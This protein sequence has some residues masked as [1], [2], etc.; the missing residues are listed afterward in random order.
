[1][2]ARDEIYAIRFQVTG[3]EEF[4]QAQKAANQL[5]ATLKRLGQ[6]TKGSGLND[7]T[8]ELEKNRK[9]LRRSSAAFQNIGYQVADFAVQVEAGTSVARAFGQQASQAFAI[10]GLQSK[11]FVGLSILAALLPGAISLFKSMT[12][13]A[14]ELA[15]AL[16][17]ASDTTDEFNKNSEGIAKVL[18]L[19]ADQTGVLRLELGRYADQLNK[20][21]IQAFVDQ[22]KEL[23]GLSGSNWMTDLFGDY[24]SK[25]AQLELALTGT[26]DKLGITQREVIA[27]NDALARITVDSTVE[28]YEN[29]ANVVS[30]IT[31]N[32]DE[33][34]PVAARTISLVLETA[35]AVRK[36]KEE[37]DGLSDS[38][39]KA[40]IASRLE[41]QSK[42]LYELQTT[43]QLIKEGWKVADA[44]LAAERDLKLLNAESEA[45]RE[46]LR[47]EFDARDQ[48]TEALRREKLA[49][50][51]LKKTRQSGGSTKQTDDLVRKVQALKEM[52]DPLERYAAKMRELREIYNTGSLSLDHYNAA[53]KKYKE[54]LIKAQE[55]TAKASEYAKDTQSAFTSFFDSAI[56]GAE[57][58]KESLKSLVKQLLKVAAQRYIIDKFFPAARGGVFSSLGLPFGVYNQPTYVGGGSRINAYAR[59]TLIGESGA[60]AVLPLT[61]T[62][63]GLGVSTS[64]AVNVNVYNN[65]PG[66]EVKTR[67]ESDGSIGIII[68][69]VRAALTNDVARGGNQFAS[70][71]EGAY[72]VNRSRSRF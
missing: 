45:V 31:S 60:E 52:V 26:A 42:T 6:S 23:T 8:T 40:K 21:R 54:E 34:N 50:E 1:M 46:N 64:G 12:S 24:I 53:F 41:S 44:Q 29:L 13:G 15:E 18:K 67:E 69:K 37:W 47:K 14:G 3:E 35:N 58:F 2:A 28:D 72:A 19:A 61:R 57:S 39:E 25:Q 66:V 70:A 36:Q 38:I 62:A 59:G 4:L 63:K 33:L 16:K 5:G 68:E 65:A 56:N 32:Y 49:Q 11:L 43:L 22:I 48:V 51:S 17:K 7:L 27:L 71:F 55:E 9:G 30:S 10:F 20:I